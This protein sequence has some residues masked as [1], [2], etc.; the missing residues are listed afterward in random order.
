MSYNK[1]AQYRVN[2]EYRVPMK[3]APNASFENV[4]MQIRNSK[5]DFNLLCDE[6][7]FAFLSIQFCLAAE[8]KYNPPTDKSIFYLKSEKIH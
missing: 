8:I 2:S 1:I 6:K 5:I 4:I 7:M 3:L